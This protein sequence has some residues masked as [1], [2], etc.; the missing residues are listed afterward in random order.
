[1]LSCFFRLVI[2]VI[3]VHQ[4]ECSQEMETQALIELSV[5]M[6]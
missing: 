6:N 3:V 1:M 2:E 4:L 5:L